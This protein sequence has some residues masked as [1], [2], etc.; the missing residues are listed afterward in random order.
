[1]KSSSN[2]KQWPKPTHSSQQ[3]TGNGIRYLMFSSDSG[4]LTCGPVDQGIELWD[5]SK[6]EKE[7]DSPQLCRLEHDEFLAE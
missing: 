7:T 6:C 1:M 3:L 2:V 4:L 5:V